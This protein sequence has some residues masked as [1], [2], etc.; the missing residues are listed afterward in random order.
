[1]GST[2]NFDCNEGFTLRGGD[3][4]TCLPSLIWRERPVI[5]DPPL[6]P[7]LDPPDN[8]FVLFP[9]TREEGDECSVVCAHGY[10]TVGPT[11]QTCVRETENLVWSDGPE[12][13][14]EC[15]YTLK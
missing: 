6:C 12:C 4:R 13:I 1:M 5:C 8:G 10:M 2:C 15:M 9:C 3:T 11:V 14:G 7:E